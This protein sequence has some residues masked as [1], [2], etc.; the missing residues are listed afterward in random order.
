MS[1]QWFYILD[2]C[3]AY[4][5]KRVWNLRR[6]ISVKWDKFNDSC[7][8]QENIQKLYIENS[9]FLKEKVLIN[10]SIKNIKA[11]QSLLQSWSKGTTPSFDSED[12]EGGVGSNY[13]SITQSLSSKDKDMTHYNKNK[14]MCLELKGI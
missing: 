7:I 6:Q 14:D 12:K 3:V 9:P 11:P 4:D 5:F 8:C 1:C 10:N 13:V 2:S